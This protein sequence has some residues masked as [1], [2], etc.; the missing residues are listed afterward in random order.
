MLFEKVRSTH[1]TDCPFQNKI[2][3]KTFRVTPLPRF[4]SSYGMRQTQS[5]DTGYEMLVN[6]HCFKKKTRVASALIA[7]VEIQSTEARRVMP[8][9]GCRVLRIEGNAI[10][11]YLCKEGLVAHLQDLS[12]P[13]L[14][15]SSPPKYVFNACPLSS[16]HSRFGNIVERR[17]EGTRPR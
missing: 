17:V 11:L 1:A 2:R 4:T 16:A 5:V 9:N 7:A 15:A 12:R 14:V 10:F 13:R 6:T 8:D 3:E